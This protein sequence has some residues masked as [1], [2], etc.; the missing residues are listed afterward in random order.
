MQMIYFSPM[1]KKKSAE[2]LVVACAN[3]ITQAQ[4]NMLVL[5]EKYYPIGSEVLVKPSRHSIRYRSYRI[6][7]YS[8]LSPGT[9]GAQSVKTGKNTILTIPFLI[10]QKRIKSHE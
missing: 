4:G 9:V 6:E 8:Y 7:S 5:L 2:Q 1:T 10:K 3:R